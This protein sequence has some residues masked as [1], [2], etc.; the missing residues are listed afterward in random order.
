MLGV[1]AHHMKTTHICLI[2]VSTFVFGCTSPRPR[3]AGSARPNVSP[4]ALVPV[5]PVFMPE[6]F[7]GDIFSIQ[8]EPSYNTLHLDVGIIKTRGVL[9]VIQ[10]SPQIMPSVIS[11]FEVTSPDVSLIDNLTPQPPTDLK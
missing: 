3:V 4:P 7:A 1:I 9:G 8:A 11:P 10:S 5:A 2:L 6:L